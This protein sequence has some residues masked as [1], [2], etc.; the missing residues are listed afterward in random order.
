V[1]TTNA[2]AKTWG[3]KRGALEIV[4]AKNTRV[5]IYDAG[6]GRVLLA[7]YADGKR[8][9]VKCQNLKAGRKRAKEII[10]QL[11]DGAAHVRTVT[12]KEAALLDFCVS[13]L[14]PL[15][16]PLS[17]AVREFADAR[18][19]LADAGEP[20]S[21]VEAAGFFVRESEKRK[22][23]PKL[24]P[25]AVQEFLDDLKAKERS[26]RHWS[27]C[28]ARLGKAAKA[29]KGQILAVTATDLERWLDSIKVKGRNRNNYRGSLTT[30]FS[31]ARKRGY[32]PRNT[33]TEAEYVTLAT[34]RGNPIRIYSPQQISDILHHLPERWIPFAAIGT[35]AGLRAAEIHRLDWSEVNLAEGH[36]V[37][38][39]QKDKTGR[40]RIVPIQPNLKA[41]LKPHAKKSGPVCPRYSHDSTLLIEFSKAFK[42]TGVLS[43]HNGFRHSYASHRLAV[44]K[45]ADEVGLEMNTSP[46]KLFQNYRELVTEKV[47]LGYFKVLPDPKRLSNTRNLPKNFTATGGPG[48]PESIQKLD[49]P[50][51]AMAA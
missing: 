41:W 44:V 47:G 5:P 24:F 37:V 50:K 21:L 38:E 18:K 40:R 19:I 46:R 6:E 16:I 35:F 2:A 20:A 45:S 4:E 39:R 30:L 15:R 25:E 49:L 10:E 29:F 23:A 42:Q 8:R 12:A 34:D 11:V 36:I 32:L 31:F 33:Q 51:E 28:H 27:D 22:V 13:V 7:Y 43:V 9:M 48:H 14:G 3:K 26:Y 1:N 17:E